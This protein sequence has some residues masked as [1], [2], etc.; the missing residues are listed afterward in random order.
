MG[1]G[2]LT[3][4]VA[5]VFMV[6]GVGA[7]TEAAMV[8]NGPH[9]CPV[10]V[11]PAEWVEDQHRGQEAHRQ[12]QGEAHR[13]CLAPMLLPDG[14]GSA[15]G[16]RLMKWRSP[17]VSGTL[18]EALTP[19][20]D[21]L[22]HQTATLLAIPPLLT[23]RMAVGMVAGV[24]GVTDGVILRSDMAG[25]VGAVDGDLVSDGVGAGVLTGVPIGRLTRIPIGIAFGGPTRTSILRPLTF[26]RIRIRKLQAIQAT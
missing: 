18:L 15:I 21:S 6:V 2:A 10:R 26:T 7:S 25:D 20:P 5:A 24:V 22:W 13:R 23:A 12:H 3:E 1:A 4:A 9:Q 17:T 8:A 19:L 14:T 16:A 11:G